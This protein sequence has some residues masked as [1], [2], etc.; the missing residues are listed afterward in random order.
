[1]PDTSPAPGDEAPDTGSPAQDAPDAGALDPGAG[2]P[3]ALGPVR[4]LAVADSDS[5]LKWAAATLDALPPSW[6]GPRPHDLVLLRSPITPSRDQVGRALHGSSRAG[7]PV[8]V[9]SPL[10][11][12]RLVR[13]TRPEV[14]L[15][16]STGPVVGVLARDLLPWARRGDEPRP[17]L[18]T[19]LPGLCVPASPLAWHH[20]RLCDLF[21]VHS[22]REAAEFTAL[23]RDL[24][25]PGQVGTARLPF[26]R[27][28]SLPDR[29]Q[30]ERLPQT[31]T[32]AEQ[33]RPE[34]PL[35]DRSQQERTQ[36]DDHPRPG[37]PQPGHP[38]PDQPLPPA[39]EVVFAAQAK[40]PRG[41]RDR[42][43]VLLAL[44]RLAARR[45]D[46]SVVVKLRAGAGEQQTHREEHDYAELWTAL[47]AAGAVRDPGALHLSTGPMSEHLARAAGLVTVSSTA[48]LEAV[49]AGVDVLLLE[50]FGVGPEMLNDVFTG[51]GCLGTLDDLVDGRFRSP[52]PAWT[53]ANYFHPPDASDWLDRL[54]ALLRLQR[55]G[56]L[57]P[58]T[59]A[60]APCRQGASPRR[61][62]VRV[63]LP[64]PVS[65]RLLQVATVR[66]RA[67]RRAGRWRARVL[68]GAATPLT[69]SAPAPA[70]RSTPAGPAGG[71]TA[72][73]PRE[74]AR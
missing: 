15:L 12:Y 7:S 17:V 32:Q 51:S 36:Q 23:A 41:D 20:R 55:A 53:G 62:R 33:P 63:L 72:A 60:P 38:Q 40:V 68:P 9:L 13:A 47:A 35:P 19:G 73:P 29:R 11:L 67:L 22:L 30:Q 42:Q 28:G 49:A 26:L 50:D 71:P 8:P 16:A 43:R 34:R 14:V 24:G 69:G 5:Y 61:A 37:H 27:D 45:P 25:L 39:R 58:S 59:A 48:A 57:P 10:A 56:R 52:S 21:V 3:E 66:R 74:P 65:Q 4:V 31:R 64:A 46:L 18:V 44:D 54:G 1:M 70:V 6:Q 2:A